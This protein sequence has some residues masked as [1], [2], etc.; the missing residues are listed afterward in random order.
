MR[1]RLWVTLPLCLIAGAA[2]AAMSVGSAAGGTRHATI[3][4]VLNVTA[5]NTDVDHSDPALAY[6]VLSWQTEYETCATLVGYK[7]SSGSVSN[8]IGPIGAAGMPV[9]TN[10]GKTLTFTVKSGMH[11]SNGD[12]IT[13]ANY[14][15]AFD[16][17]ALKN[18]NSPVSAFMGHVKGWTAENTNAAVHS[19]SGVTTSGAGAGKLIVNLS[20]KDGTILPVLALPF[21]CPLDKTAPFWTGSQWRDTEVNGPWPGSGPYYLFSRTPTA[22]EV[23]KTNTHYNGSQ[24]SVAQTINITMGTSTNTAYNGISAGTYASDLNGNPEPANNH[25]LFTTYGK[26]TSRF[27]VYSELAVS[28]LAMN[29]ARPTF[30]KAHLKVRQAVNNVVD[31]PGIAAIAGY[32][33]GQPQTQPLPKPLAGS[34]FQTNYKYPITT[35]N[36]ARFNAAKTQSNNCAGHAHI[37]FWHGASAPALQAASLDSYD[38]SQMG[39][40]V[41]SVSYP[42]FGRYVAA[43]IRGNS[44][45]IM[46]AGWVDDYP[47]GWDWYGILFNGR[48]IVATSNNDLAYMNNSI[49]NSKADYCNKQVGATRTNCFGLLDQYNTANVAPWAT[50]LSTNFVDYIAPNAHGYHFDGPFGSVDLGLFYQS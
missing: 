23:L 4:A 29:E 35:P 37:N 34:H 2:F 17:D 46:T 10:A 28:Y 50:T 27:W 30:T 31:R 42:G 9:I 19:V 39:C 7:D 41:N 33:S 32:L 24:K 21:F 36:A 43:G 3:N 40:V 25:A 26:N 1:K 38:L 16:R 22:Q 6:G 18:L 14:K 20:V 47:D 13:A 45:D 12:P 44:M 49:V 15:A 48:T 8:S 11:F 5:D